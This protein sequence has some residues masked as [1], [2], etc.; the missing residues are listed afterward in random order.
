MNDDKKMILFYFI[1]KT[2]RATDTGRIKR[3]FDK[4]ADRNANRQ[5]IITTSF[6]Y[7]KNNNITTIN[8][9]NNINSNA[10]L[11]EMSI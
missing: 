9:N 6:I 4:Q 8:K 10:E 7:Y 2:T 11:S 5:K 1:V 3:S